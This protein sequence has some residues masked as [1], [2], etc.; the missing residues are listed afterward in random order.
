MHAEIKWVGKDTLGFSFRTD[1][2]R[3]YAEASRLETKTLL[4]SPSSHLF[5]FPRE[6]SMH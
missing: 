6:R 2:S 3:L 1:T 4:L 5:L